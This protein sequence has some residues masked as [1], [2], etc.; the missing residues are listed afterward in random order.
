MKA[1]DAIVG[2]KVQ[3]KRSSKWYSD[4][5]VDNPKDTTGCITSFDLDAAEDGD[6]SIQVD[7]SNGY[8]NGYRLVDLKLV[9]E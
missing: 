6:F 3:I 5:D 7:W 9:K 2:A 4:Q 1:K 8:S